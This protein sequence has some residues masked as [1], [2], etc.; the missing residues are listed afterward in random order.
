MGGQEA[1]D[2]GRMGVRCA[3]RNRRKALFLGR[4]VSAGR[5]VDGEYVPGQVSR[6]RYR[7]RRLRW[8]S[9]PS[10]NFQPTATA[11][12]IW[13]A[14]FGNGAP[15]GTGRTFTPNAP[16]NAQKGTIVRNPQGPSSSF[17][18]AEPRER[19]RVHRGGSFLCTEEYCTRYMI[20]SRGK[21]EI[22]SASNHLGFRCVKAAK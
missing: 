2:R 16:A 14:T 10:L 11:C 21:G 7:G 22:S 20:G 18:P 19:K 1:A 8:A 13:P 12:S 3:G 9:H 6:E 5:A 17:D 15:T 4:A